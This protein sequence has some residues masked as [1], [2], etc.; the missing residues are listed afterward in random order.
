MSSLLAEIFERARPIV[1]EHIV[2]EGR[3]VVIEER[4]VIDAR[5]KKLLVRPRHAGLSDDEECSGPEILEVMDTE[6][7]ILQRLYDIV[8]AL[9]D[10]IGE[11]MLPC[12]AD[13]GQMISDGL[14]GGCDG[15]RGG[16][17][18]DGDPFVEVG[19][20]LLIVI[21]IVEDLVV[22]LEHGIGVLQLRAYGEMVPD[23]FDIRPVVI[24]PVGLLVEQR[25]YEL[26]AQVL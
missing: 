12:V 26:V 21:C 20:L 17:T 11:T 2:I 7:Y 18:K 22:I 3:E 10:R 14:H 23:A 4:A 1:G 16:L 24:A 15:L 9:T 5:I 8:V 25:G 6:A 13:I 19:G